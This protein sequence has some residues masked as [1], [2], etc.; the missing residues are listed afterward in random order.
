MAINYEFNNITGSGSVVI[1]NT[2]NFIS[3]LYVNNIPVS[4]SGHTHYIYEISGNPVSGMGVSNYLTKWIN[5][6]GIT[7]GIIY[8]DDNN[9]I[10]INTE[11]PSADFHLIGSGIINTGIFSQIIL[12]SGAP[13]LLNN[14]PQIIF[15]N[16][17]K[18]TV[19]DDTIKFE[20]FDLYNELLTITKSGISTPNIYNSQIHGGYFW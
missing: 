12:T 18:L 7:T 15:N 17:I 13:F 3:G 20:G 1:Y 9:R 2:G 14:Y 10:G 6:S 8:Q 4:L 19:L 5:E 16:G 11:T